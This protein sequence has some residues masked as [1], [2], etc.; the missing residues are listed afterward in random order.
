MYHVLFCFEKLPH[1]SPLLYSFQ[2]YVLLTFP[3][4]GV[5]YNCRSF[6]SLLDILFGYFVL[7]S[8]TRWRLLQTSK[9]IINSRLVPYDKSAFTKKKKTVQ[10]PLAGFICFE[11]SSYHHNILVSFAIYNGVIQCQP[12]DL[13]FFL[14]LLLL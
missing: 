14:L 11:M 13:A 3:Y 8:F 5:S 4:I 6:I 2:L 9:K 10:G 12:G 1:M 7:S